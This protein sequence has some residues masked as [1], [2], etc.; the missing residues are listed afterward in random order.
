MLFILN[1]MMVGIYCVLAPDVNV[2][3]MEEENEMGAK[4]P[5]MI[6]NIQSKANVF[7]CVLGTQYSIDGAICKEMFDK[8]GLKDTAVH[9]WQCPNHLAM[10]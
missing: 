8:N 3:N 6:N 2:Q 9:P 7:L 10:C 5:N 1:Y 4:C